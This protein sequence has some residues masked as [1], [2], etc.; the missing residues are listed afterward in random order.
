MRKHMVGGVQLGVHKAAF[1]FGEWKRGEWMGGERRKHCQTRLGSR[2]VHR[3][4]C[5][6]PACFA[7]WFPK[8][9]LPVSKRGT[10]GSCTPNQDSKMK[11]VVLAKNTLSKQG[12]DS[13]YNVAGAV[14]RR[15]R[16]SVVNIKSTFSPV[17]ALVVKT[18]YPNV[19]AICSRSALSIARSST[20]SDLLATRTNLA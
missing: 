2:N 17:L 16:A 6:L 8:S 11:W 5:R 7:K 1:V 19:A 14:Q 10:F 3:G 13:Y 4:R 18:G 12:Y 9:V 20:R 15:S